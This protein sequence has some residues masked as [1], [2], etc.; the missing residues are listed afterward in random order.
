MCI[1]TIKEII[2]A[3]K[4]FLTKIASTSPLT[5]FC[6]VT[7]LSFGQVILFYFILEFSLCPV[8][9]AFT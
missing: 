4:Y 3:H 5:V 8:Y 2:V 1:R 9:I 7:I 6:N